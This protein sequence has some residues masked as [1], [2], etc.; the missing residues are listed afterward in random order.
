MRTQA[1]KQPPGSAGARE[2]VEQALSLDRTSTRVAERA[3]ARLVTARAEFNEFLVDQTIFDVSAA[4]SQLQVSIGARLFATSYQVTCR[5]MLADSLDDL[6]SAGIRAP[7]SARDPDASSAAAVV[8][9]EANAIAAAAEARLAAEIHVHTL[10][11]AK[12]AHDAA[13]TA[14]ATVAQAAEDARRARELADALAAVDIATAATAAAAD[15]QRRA[16]EVAAM[17]SAAAAIAA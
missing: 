5:A 13:V 15:V 8:L 17:V 14:A 10:G 9:A 2:A 11:V 6:T 1:V 4:A 7:Q 16:Q 12:T 3:E